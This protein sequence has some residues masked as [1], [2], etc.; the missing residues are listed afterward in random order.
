MDLQRPSVPPHK[1]HLRPPPTAPNT[2]NSLRHAGQQEL[3]KT[4]Q[5][6][7]AAILAK[8]ELLA[9]LEKERDATDKEIALKD[10]WAMMLQKQLR[11]AQEARQE[12]QQSGITFDELRDRLQK[13]QM[14]LAHTRAMLD[15]QV[16]A[17]TSVLC[18]RVLC[19]CAAPMCGDKS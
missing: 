11:D 19:L 7:D 10:K 8:N 5:K 4:T 14:E 12:E 9:V 18:E 13:S 16:G 1:C 6:N 15:L 2:D 3:E 17:V